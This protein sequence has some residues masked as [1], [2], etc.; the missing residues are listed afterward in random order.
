MKKLLIVIL[1]LA[2]AMPAAALAVIPDISGLSY[3]ELAELD[4]QIH[5]AMFSERLLGGVKIPVGNYTI[6]VDIPA[7]VYRIEVSADVGLLAI[8][9]AEGK[10]V[11]S[12]VI[13]SVYYINEI[14]KIT[15]EDG[16]VIELTYCNVMLYP[17]EGLF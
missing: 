13:G 2:I 15:F 3:D 1:I 14:G 5:L 11:G 17:Y 4:R 10:A 7:G 16:Q 6:G 12:Y 8:Y 9:S